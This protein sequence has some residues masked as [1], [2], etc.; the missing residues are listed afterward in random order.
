MAR[1]G[2]GCLAHA[3][4]SRLLAHGRQAMVARHG[5]NRTAPA[6]S[7]AARSAP[8]VL[9]AVQRSATPPAAVPYEREPSQP[10][11]THR[12]FNSPRRRR[13]S[14]PAE[15]QQV[16]GFA[17]PLSLRLAAI[18]IAQLC[19]TSTWP[20]SVCVSQKCNERSPRMPKE[21]RTRTV[22]PRWPCH[23]HC[24]LRSSVSTFANTT[25]SQNSCR[26]P[27]SITTTP[28]DSRVISVE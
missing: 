17:A 2:H 10:G 23:D 14:A 9:D 22:C 21:R 15:T 3:R 6:P 25:R 5:P 27:K 7:C 20:S 26:H 11:A 28:K 4:G 1:Y 24:F 13:A 12:S 16:P 18:K 8:P 19:L